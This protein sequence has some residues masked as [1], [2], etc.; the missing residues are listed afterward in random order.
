MNIEPI[1]YITH[2]YFF[3]TSISMDVLGFCAFKRISKSILKVYSVDGSIFDF[4]FLTS[5]CKSFTLSNFHKTIFFLYLIY[6]T[7]ISKNQAL[8]SSNILIV[9][10]SL[11]KKNTSSNCFLVGAFLLFLREEVGLHPTAF[12]IS[13]AKISLSF[14]FIFIQYTL[15]I[16]FY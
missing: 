5:S 15:I 8:G 11:S 6:L 1:P 14:L 2:Q 16:L 7:T 10:V 3:V 4:M 12:F 13:F 9:I